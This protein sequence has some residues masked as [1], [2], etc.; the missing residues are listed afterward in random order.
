MN[1]ILLPA[2]LAGSTRVAL[3][4]PPPHAPLTPTAPTLPIPLVKIS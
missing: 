1:P 3:H 4:E 2:A